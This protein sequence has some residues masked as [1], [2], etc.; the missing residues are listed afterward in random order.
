MIQVSR[1]VVLTLISQNAAIKLYTQDAYTA[2][3]LL[4][5]EVGKREVYR[6]YK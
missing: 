3:Y 4:Y 2:C 1:C 5:H 6:F